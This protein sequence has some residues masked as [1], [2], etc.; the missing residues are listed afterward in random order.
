MSLFRLRA[1]AAVV[2][3]VSSVVLAA[4]CGGDEGGVDSWPEVDVEA[5]D[6]AVVST[7]DLVGDRPL[8]VTLW[9][10]WCQPCRREMP[11]LQEIAAERAADVDVVGVNIGD[12]VDRVEE[13]LDE[14]AV[15]FPAY[16]DLDGLLLSRLGVPSV[17]ATAV[18]L[19]NGELTWLHLGE[20]SKAQVEA[21]ID[22]A[23]VDG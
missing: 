12:D 15:T 13:F 7:A 8:V 6:G 5:L 21:A 20:A 11:A 3:A 4:G 22:D 2:A 14:I 19:P 18:V 17:P 16:R 23:L 9:A 1:S 10:V